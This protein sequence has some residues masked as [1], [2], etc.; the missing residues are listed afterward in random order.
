MYRGLP[1]AQPGRLPVAADA[2]RKA[3]CLP[4]YPALEDAQVDAIARILREPEA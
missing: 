4:I 1:S 2:A 3:L